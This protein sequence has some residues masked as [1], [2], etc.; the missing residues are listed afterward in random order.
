MNDR[1]WLVLG[2]AMILV[3]GSYARL[4]QAPHAPTLRDPATAATWMIDALPG[5]AGKR[6]AETLAAVRHEDFTHLQK[7]ARECAEKV[8]NLGPADD[9]RIPHPKEPVRNR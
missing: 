1:W 8:F 2:I 4:H 6:L 3:L 7:P 9:D 5:I